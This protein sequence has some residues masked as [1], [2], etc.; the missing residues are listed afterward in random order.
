[1]SPL[2]KDIIEFKDFSTPIQIAEFS[3][4]KKYPND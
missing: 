2:E 3:E 4:N 1:M